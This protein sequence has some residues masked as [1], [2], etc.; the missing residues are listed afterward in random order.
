MTTWG[1]TLSSEEFGPRE[2]AA[3]AVAAEEAGFEFLTVSDH[4]HPWTE[5]QGHSPFVWTTIAAASALTSRIRIGTGV[6]CPIMRI[7]PAVVA[8]AAASSSAVS[9]G[10]FFLGIGT[11]EALNEHIIGERW[12]SIEER[13][14]ML[15]EAVEIMRA[16]WTGDTVDFRG[17]YFQVENARLFTRPVENI[18]LIMAASGP[19]SAEMA[20]AIADGLWSTHADADLVDAYRTAGGAGPVIGQVTLCWAATEKE[21]R[22]TALRIWPNAGIPG[23]LSQDLP[24]WTH[25]QQVSELVTAEK[26]AERV[27]SGPDLQP[28]VDAVREY[29]KAGFDHVHF[30]QVGQDQAGFFRFWSEELSAAL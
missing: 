14:E 27:P 20:A 23:Q 9:G 19:E 13:R 16:L 25:F 5:S 22:E 30:H 21:G 3:N 10:R 28:V 8:H 2:L 7:H 6:T 4:F 29:E 12:P 15:E 18:D 17:M 24:T 1:Y 26:L 11:G